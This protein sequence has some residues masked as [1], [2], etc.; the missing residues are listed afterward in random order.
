MHGWVTICGMKIVSWNVNSLNV[1]LPHVL[2][3]LG[4]E[5]PDVLALQE[6]K[7]PDDKFPVADIEAAGYRVAYSGQ[8]TYNGVAIISRQSVSDVVVDLPGLDDPQRR[9]MAASIDGIR[10]IDVYIPN[11]QEVGS[12]KYAYKMTWLGALRDFLAGEVSRHERLVLLGDF[13]IAPA[14]IDVHD[15]KRWHEKIMCSSEER[16]K[17]NSLLGLG[18]RD[19]VR[20]LYPDEPMHS[21]WDYRLNAF[22]RQ[23]GIRI[24]LVLATAGMTSVG[25]GVATEFR[26][27]ERPSDHAPVWVDFA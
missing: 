18:L 25:G 22:R 5:K 17:F 1:R 6:T 21:W 20:G 15:P 26:A 12:E 23:W 19:C 13:N 16:E 9:L 2:D 27:L 4:R 10:I 8:K 14:D 7:L 24:D 3:F 11:G